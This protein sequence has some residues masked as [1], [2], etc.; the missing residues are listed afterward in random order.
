MVFFEV[1]KEKKENKENKKPYMIKTKNNRMIFSS[2]FV[3]VKSRDLSTS[4]KLMVC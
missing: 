3:I 2:K 4:S 1:N